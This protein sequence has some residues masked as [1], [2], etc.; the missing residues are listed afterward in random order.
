MLKTP[1]R[2]IKENSLIESLKAFRFLM[3]IKLKSRTPAKIILEAVKKRGGECSRAIFP[4][5]NMLDHP[6]YIKITKRIDISKRISVEGLPI[7]PPTEEKFCLTGT[8]AR[9]VLP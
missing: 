5:E 9:D 1:R 7:K 3:S 2:A 6:A 8:R 4:K